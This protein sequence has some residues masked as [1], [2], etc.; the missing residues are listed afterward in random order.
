MCVDNLYTYMLYKSKL[1]T[2]HIYICTLKASI[3]I[4][5]SQHFERMI[6]YC[7]SEIILCDSLVDSIEKESHTVAQ[8]GS[9]HTA[10]LPPLTSESCVTV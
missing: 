3:K 6:V 2:E 10:I 8:A 1:Y 4:F 9:K 7:V 5:I